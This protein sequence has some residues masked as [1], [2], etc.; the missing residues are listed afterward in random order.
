LGDRPAATVLANRNASRVGGVAVPPQ[1]PDVTAE[2]LR[3]ERERDREDGTGG[4]LRQDLRRCDRQGY[5][6][7][8]RD[9]L[10]PVARR[11]I[12][13]HPGEQPPGREERVTRHYDREHPDPCRRGDLHAKGENQESVDLAVE[14]RAQR[15]RRLCTSRDPSVDEVERERN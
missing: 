7:Y 12:R 4:S 9:R 3:E 14:A 6:L 15:R 11:Q 5:S 2:R 13:A 8:C 1:P 10:A